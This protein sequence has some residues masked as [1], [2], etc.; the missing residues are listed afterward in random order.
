LG[1]VVK[2]ANNDGEGRNLYFRA[3]GGEEE[4]SLAGQK[5]VWKNSWVGALTKEEVI[6][7][8][9]TVKRRARLSEGTEKSIRIERNPFQSVK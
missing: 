3:S 2:N 6:S 8:G 5:V 9:N 1:N 4:I 7:G